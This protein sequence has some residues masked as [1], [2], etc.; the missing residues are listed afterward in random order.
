MATP[1]AGYHT[2]D[3]T[4]VPSVTTI[5]GRF[6]EAGGL[7]HWAWKLGTEGQDY[8]K[9]RDEAADAGTMAHEAVE[10]W[11]HGYEYEWV[12]EP[13]VVAN[14]QN[15]FK[16][17]RTWIDQTKLEVI[18]T[19][20]PLVSE[21]YRYGGT[22][23]AIGRIDNT[24]CLLDWKSSNSVYAD[25]LIQ[26]AAYRQLWEETHLDQ[27]IVGGYH[28][29]RFDKKTGDFTHH[30]WRNL[31]DAWECFKL[32]RTLYDALKPLEKRVK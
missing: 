7:M 4:K 29:L 23:D 28:L 16:A 19:E 6:K 24:L 3:G 1:K 14:A 8:R 26:L 30:H 17:F 20:T 15:S 11:L 5:L 25:Y 10:A 2:K 21:V 31:D 18:E 9:V 32:M 13:D 27:P 22:P 12:G